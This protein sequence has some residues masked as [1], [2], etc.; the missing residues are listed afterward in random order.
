MAAFS[1]FV[2][3]HKIE[4]GIFVLALVVR[5]L[6]LGISIDANQGNVV[7]SVQGADGYYTISQNLIQG[8][9]FSG[10]TEPPYTL[11]SFRPPLQPYFL[12]ST[13]S[14]FGN[15]WLP[16]LLLLVIGS[17][18]P[19]IAMR[20]APFLVDSRAVAVGTGVILALEPVS[21]L[22]S[23]LFYS[24]TLFMLFFSLF[25]YFAFAYVK[26]EVWYHGVFAAALL[27]LATLTKAVS[28]YLPLVLVPLFLLHFRKEL[29]RKRVFAAFAFIAVFLLVL[30]P[31]L[32]R[33]YREFNSIGI[34]SEEGVTLY[35]VII[36]SILAVE[37]G[38]SF[39]QEYAAWTAN[40]V[41]G[42]NEATIDL[43]ARYIREAIPVILAHPVGLLL[44]TANTS[45]A[46]FTHD[47]M[48]DVLRHVNF[49][50]DQLL[51]KPAL[52]L[53][54]SDPMKLLGF[55]GHY[56]TTPAVLI[57]IMR[58]A[59]FIA[60]FLFFVGAVQSMRRQRHSFY[61]TVAFCTVLYFALMTLSIGLTVNSRY[62]L[63]VEFLIIPFALYG[64]LYLKGRLQKKGIV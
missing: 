25:I 61:A 5:C 28:M 49:K 40:G 59:W 38:T 37:R 3:A 2:R 31:W 54:L 50:A 56:A 46:F 4:I 20:I 43:N 22:Y 23:T 44:L 6:Y 11:N 18:I 15:Y 36:P 17:C 9:G 12:A 14:V 60:T 1:D 35:T 47:G 19:L 10:E 13:Y 30:S 45:L 21:I 29:T 64:F 58:I 41:K 34:T 16:I 39:Q 57:L 62:R 42:P 7:R 53:L 55:I 32:Y 51:G 8:R 63:P 24:E 27:G 52:F 33:N 48:F 26:E